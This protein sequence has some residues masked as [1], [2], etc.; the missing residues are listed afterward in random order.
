MNK[1]Q[2]QKSREI[3]ALMRSDKWGRMTYK[4]ARRKW[5]FLYTWPTK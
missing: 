4:E 1:Y 2:K 3:K 5:R